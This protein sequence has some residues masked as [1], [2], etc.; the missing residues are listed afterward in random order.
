M[1]EKLSNTDAQ[2]SELI[3]TLSERSAVSSSFGSL[4]FDCDA[5]HLIMEQGELREMARWPRTGV[6]TNTNPF[7]V[8]CDLPCRKNCELLIVCPML[9]LA[10]LEVCVT[11]LPA[12][13]LLF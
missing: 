7:D 6:K 9:I 11:K 1:K 2:A 12:I 4:Y 13:V 5:T 10:L 3:L 8:K